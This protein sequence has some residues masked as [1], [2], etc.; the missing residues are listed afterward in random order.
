MFEDDIF[1]Q[2][3]THFI[4]GAIASVLLL[5]VSIFLVFGAWKLSVQFWIGEPVKTEEFQR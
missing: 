3:L 5:C 1:K 2:V 4:V